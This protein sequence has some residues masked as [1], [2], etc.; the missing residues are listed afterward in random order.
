MTQ[1]IIRT[2]GEERKTYILRLDSQKGREGKDKDKV[3]RIGLIYT[4]FILR[5]GMRDISAEDVVNP[6]N[7]KVLARVNLLKGSKLISV[8]KFRELA[9]INE[10]GVYTERGKAASYR[11]V[12]RE[13]LL[14]TPGYENL[15]GREFLTHAYFL[16]KESSSSLSQVLCFEKEG[17][18]AS[19]VESK[20]D[21]IVFPL[22]SLPLIF[23]QRI[24][25]QDFIFRF[26]RK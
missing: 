22:I 12:S 2:D 23:Y 13:A 1:Y 6:I 26:M 15:E 14:S 18:L 5:E 11:K 21:G 10:S 8:G 19:I 24:S 7:K 3:E 16:G 9:S 25:D 17:N 20:N 4:D